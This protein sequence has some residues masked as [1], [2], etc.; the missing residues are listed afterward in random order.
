MTTSL[1]L[2]ADQNSTSSSIAGINAN[3]TNQA[4]AIAALQSKDATTVHTSDLSSAIMAA[5]APLVSKDL[6]ASTIAPLV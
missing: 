4:S 5:V 1:N 6:L 2:K 3:L